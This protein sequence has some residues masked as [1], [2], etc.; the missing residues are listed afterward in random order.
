MDRRLDTRSHP[1]RAGRRGR[2]KALALALPALAFLAV[3]LAYPLQE[4]LRISFARSGGL[5]PLY[6]DP[7]YLERAWFTFWQAGLSAL[8]TLALALPLGWVLA[9]HTFRGKATLEAL[10][11]VPFVLPTIVVAVAF[12]ALIGPN[13]SF[14]DLL[15]H[16]PG[17]DRPPIHLLDTL[18]AILLAH[19]FYNVAFSARII[20]SGW[21]AIDP[22]TEDAAAMLGAGPVGRFRWVT[23]P[24][25]RNSLLAAGSLSFLFCFTSFGVVLILGGPRFSTIETE[26]YRESL[27]LFRLP[28]A[29]VLA[30]AQM[31]MTF[32]VIGFNTRLQRDLGVQA[33]RREPSR[34][35]RTSMLAAVAIVGFVLLLTVA[36]L[37]ALV[38]RSFHAGDGYSWRYYRMLDENVRGQVL[39]VAPI[40]AVRNSLVIATFTALL[41]VPLGT[42]AALGAVR[43]RSTLVEAVIQAPLGVSAVTL[44]L[45]FLITFDHPPLNLRASP[46]LV[47]LA[48]TLVAMPFVARAMA[49]RLR[50]LDPRLRDAAA[51]LGA[52]PIATFVQVE[53]P[54]LGG[55]LALGAVLSFAASMG[56]FGATLLIARPEYPTIPVAI[57]RYLGQPGAT[58][59]GQA[60]AMSSIL[61]AV[62]A[63]GFFAIERGLG[64]R[65]TGF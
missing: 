33:I 32:A 11:L 49:A 14:N 8:L 43:A 21:R 58:N 39:F 64:R 52:N 28:V 19:V 57:Y 38:E 46:S 65:G 25:L 10:L 35:S 42:L 40:T 59:Y 4:I 37:V 51:M 36:P 62:T 26:I 53:L 12:S 31:A 23:L 50:S 16:L 29:A 41:A 18:W 54:L 7:Y 30:L 60:L 45:G 56:E 63:V 9:C 48:H 2:W 34:F 61:M 6:E 17:I 13:G 24:L 3:F 20:A 47:V 22:R 1:L 5:R 55:A 27:F 44:G 15:T